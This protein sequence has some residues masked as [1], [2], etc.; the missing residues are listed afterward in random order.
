MK[1]HLWSSLL[2]YSAV[3]SPPRDLESKMLQE[4]TLIDEKHSEKYNISDLLQSSED[5]K[6]TQFKCDFI[7]LRFSDEEYMKKG[8]PGMALLYKIWKAWNRQYERECLFFIIK[9]GGSRHK[10]LTPDLD[11][12]WLTRFM[13]MLALR[14]M[15]QKGVLVPNTIWK[16][17]SP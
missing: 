14:R 3:A 13:A 2:L 5:K 4:Y 7:A 1:V 8:T 16:E 17:N 9:S 12:G 10:S 11:D 15:V 6:S